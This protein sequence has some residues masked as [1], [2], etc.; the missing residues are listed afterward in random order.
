MWKWLILPLS[1]FDRLQHLQCIFEST[2]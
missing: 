2:Q 1:V